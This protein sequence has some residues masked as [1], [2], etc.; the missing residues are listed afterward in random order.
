MSDTRTVAHEIVA[1]LKALMAKG[2]HSRQYGPAALRADMDTLVESA[3]LAAQAGGAKMIQQQLAKFI[4]WHKTTPND[5][6]IGDSRVAYDA[7]TRT[8]EQ[9]AWYLEGRDD[10]LNTIINFASKEL[11]NDR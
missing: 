3:L 5:S 7:G 11:K 2:E 6:L 9:L 4:H 8:L 10:Y 1:K